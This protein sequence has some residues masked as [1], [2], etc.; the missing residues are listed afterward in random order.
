MSP[1]LLALLFVSLDLQMG[2]ICGI[3]TVVGG[4]KSHGVSRENC[5]SNSWDNLDVYLDQ[6]S[7]HPFSSC[8]KNMTK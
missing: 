5:P 3:S 2:P 1:S 6:V 7:D 8:H 4:M